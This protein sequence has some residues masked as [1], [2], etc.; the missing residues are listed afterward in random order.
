MRLDKNRHDG[1]VLMYVISCKVLIKGGPFNKSWPFFGG[2]TSCT[3][4]RER[5]TSLPAIHAYSLLRSRDGSD[6]SRNRKAAG[7]TNNKSSSRKL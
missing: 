1:V 7:E 6:V 4:T 2:W 3:G 5:K